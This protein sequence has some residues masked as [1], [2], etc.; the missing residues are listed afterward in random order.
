MRMMRDRLLVAGIAGTAV[1]L[2]CC[3]TPALAVLFAALGMSAAIGWIDIV[4]FPALAIFLIMT[5]YAIWL[6][7]RKT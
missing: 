1:T 2:I 6:R 7:T 5:G 4:L 3:F